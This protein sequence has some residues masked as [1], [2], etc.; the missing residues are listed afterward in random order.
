VDA[1]AL[2]LRKTID[3]VSH[4]KLF[5]ALLQAGVPP[6]IVNIILVGIQTWNRV[7]FCDPVTRKSSDPETQSTR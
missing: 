6:P 1:A 7:T 3:S 5:G 4:F 2:D